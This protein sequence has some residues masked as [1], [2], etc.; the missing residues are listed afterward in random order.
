MSILVKLFEHN[1]WANLR[2]VEACAGL[3]DA[4]LGATVA[5]TAGSVRDTLM[6]IAGAEQ[7]YVERLSGRRPTY[8]ERDG[9]P[10]TEALRQALDES[11]GALIALAG[12]A[13]P[14]EVLRGEYQGRPVALPV[15]TLYV[16]AI[17]HATEHRSQIATILTQQGV[18]P[19]DFS[20][21]AWGR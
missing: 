21:W 11:G 10:G 17:N 14:D 16:Q 19:P 4:H 2:A 13:D 8:G 18:E 6:H 9:W 15:A 12:N 3:D 7:R 1:R 5:G 20:G